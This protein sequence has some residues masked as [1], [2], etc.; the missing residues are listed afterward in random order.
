M[1]LGLLVEGV[2]GLTWQRWR[3][4][5]AA[6][7]RLGFESV[8][9]SD[10]L[11]SLQDCARE[12]LETWVALS[13]AAAETRRIR[14]GPLVSPITFRHPSLLA[15]MAASLDQLSGG[16]F[17][18]GLGVGWNELEHRAFGL[19]FP[20]PAERFDRL[21][22]GLWVIR[23][24]QGDAPAHFRGRYYRVEGADPRPK[25]VAGTLPILVAGGGERRTL[26][27][28]ARYADEWDV[29]GG[30]APEAF[31]AKS[32]QLDGL[33]RATGREPRSILRSAS[34][35]Y[36]IARDSEELGARLDRLRRHTPALA[37]L[38]DAG[39]LAALRGWNW[40]I[41]TPEQLAEDFRA[42]A[43]AG[44]ERI[45]LQHNDQ[46]DLDALELLAREVM[47]RVDAWT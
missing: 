5:V 41:G 30:L 11:L 20:P 32:V 9:L 42:L 15:R 47:P 33:C 1:K 7:E 40:R 43:E 34:T 19:E 14:L 2:E 28:V 38:D 18:L 4:L 27:L 44:A 6:A 13:V 8:W 12:G 37:G 23:A 3:R 21:D 10:H 36:L 29:P 35:A 46:D 26:P 31:R 16:R 17:V 45:V 24:L 39:A 22:E 25:P